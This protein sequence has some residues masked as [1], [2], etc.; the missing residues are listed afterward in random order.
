MLVIDT[1]V[2]VSALG[3]PDKFTKESQQFF[4]SLNGNTQLIL[5]ALVVWETVAAIF[6]QNILTLR[7]VTKYFELLDIIPLDM[8]YLNLAISQLPKNTVLKSSDLIV[9]LTAKMKHATLITWDNQLLGNADEF[10]T[11]L[12]PKQ[13]LIKNNTIHDEKIH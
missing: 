1:N 10:C 12:T 6:K 3:R 2:F 8:Q 11:V 4:K 7:V 9:A 13:Y 5:P